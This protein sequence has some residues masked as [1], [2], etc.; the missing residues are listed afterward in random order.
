VSNAFPQGHFLGSTVSDG[1]EM[2]LRC[3]ALLFL[4]WKIVTY[5]HR[6]AAALPFTFVL[7]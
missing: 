5:E 1:N 7:C 2:K 6:Y 4:Q 3:F